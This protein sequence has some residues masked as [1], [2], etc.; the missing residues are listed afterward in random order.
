VPAPARD[1]CRGLPAV[2]ASGRDLGVHPARRLDQL[3]AEAL[4]RQARAVEDG[5]APFDRAIALGD[6]LGGA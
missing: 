1:D 5:A 2:E 6:D 4:E 3:V